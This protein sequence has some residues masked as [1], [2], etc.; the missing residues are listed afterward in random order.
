MLWFYTLTHSPSKLTPPPAN[1]KLLRIIYVNCQ[2]LTGNVGA[3][4]KLLHSTKPDVMKA[5]EVWLD[6][7][8]TNA[9][10]ERD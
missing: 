3:C 8:V 6:S 9:E 10:L 4:A 1:D 2:S 5:S 7:S